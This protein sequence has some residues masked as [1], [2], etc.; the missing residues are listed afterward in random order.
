MGQR[1]WWLACAA[2]AGCAGPNAVATLPR[3]TDAYR[4]VPAAA[5]AAGAAAY[6]IA[7]RDLLDVSVFAEPELS[8]KGVAVDGAGRIALPLAGSF[9]AGGR[10]A[11]ELGGEIERRLAASYLR[12][13][14]VTVS[15]AAPAPRT[16]VV[17]GEVREPGS[18]PLGG[19][20]GLLGALSLARGETRVAALSE[21]LVFRTVDGRR[22][23][24]VFDVNRIR[25]GEAPDPAI[26]GDDLVV[27][28]YSNKRG[29][30]R[31]F[32]QA[33]PLVSAFRPLG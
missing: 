8:A 16:V 33:S 9:D 1:G 25:R 17:E 14:R 21:V 19:P 31:D 30:W 32:L 18:Y 6:R 22:V 28:G 2:L 3:G 7:P 4:V 13:P 5:P 24:A 12:H 23:G 27:V 10:T 26:L 29:W 20:T 11:A 15:V